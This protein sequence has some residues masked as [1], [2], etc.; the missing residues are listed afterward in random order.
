MWGCQ[1]H[2][3]RTQALA[4][5]PRAKSETI[6]VRNYYTCGENTLTLAIISMLGINSHCEKILGE[7]RAS[8]ADESLWV[9]VE[10][11]H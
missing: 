1:K 6:Y 7:A 9:H 4:Y 3:L 10:V 8:A 5:Y 11:A 2:G